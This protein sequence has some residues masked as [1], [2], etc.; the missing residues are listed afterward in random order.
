MSLLV[1]IGHCGQLPTELVANALSIAVR[2]DSAA[3]TTVTDGAACVLQCDSTGALRTTGSGGGGDASAANQ[4]S[5][6]SKIETVATAV[7]VE[8]VAHADGDA[9]IASLAVRKDSPAS[10]AGT[11]GDYA[12]CQV[13]ASGSLWVTD[14]GRA[15]RST[16]SISGSSWVKGDSKGTLDTASYTNVDFAIVFSNATAT[17]ADWLGIELSHDNSTWIPLQDVGFQPVTDSNS[18]TQFV[19]RG[20]LSGLAAQYVRFTNTCATQTTLSP[21]YLTL[22]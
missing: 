2:K 22:H 4:T 18:A 15:A 17:A 6:I 9:G 19:C 16:V 7:H 1:D 11:A 14:A 10:L 3:S 8:D 12:P 21:L 13:D 5:M 20:S